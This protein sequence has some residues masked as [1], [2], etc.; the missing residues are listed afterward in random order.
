M[1]PINILWLVIACVGS[2][3]L[4]S[5]P[6]S[7]WIGKL[8]TGVDLREHNVKNPGGM[9]AVRTYGIAIG[10]PILL[11]DFFKGTLTIMILDH[12]FNLD[13]FVAADGS[14]IWY[15]LAVILGPAFCVIGHNYPV[16][17]KFEGGQGLG[18]FMGATLYLNPIVFIFYSLAMIFIMTVVKM[19]VRYGTMVVII[20]EI[21]LAL[22][23]PISPPWSNLAANEF[24]TLPGFLELKFA[25]ILIAMF[26]LIALRAV[27]AYLKGKKTA[28]WKVGENGEQDFSDNKSKS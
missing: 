28:T 26:L 21:I 14:N 2:Y 15:T 24:T 10:L 1:A 13:Y 5:I 11:L 8:A 27:G 4:G 17:L 19:N 20:A 12:L 25:L 23:M 18:V 16:W 3:L 7:V 22:F 6:F 9:N